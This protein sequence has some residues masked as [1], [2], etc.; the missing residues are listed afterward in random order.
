MLFEDILSRHPAQPQEFRRSSHHLSKRTCSGTGSLVPTQGRRWEALSRFFAPQQ[1]AHH[2]LRANAVH[3]D[4]ASVSRAK[5]TLI[6]RKPRYQGMT[7]EA[8]LP[9]C[10]RI[11]LIILSEFD[12]FGRDVAL[13]VNERK[14]PGSCGVK[15][16][17]S[18]LSNG[19]YFCRPQAG[20]FVQTN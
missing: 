14:A 10:L 20:N 18:N 9:D 4:P 3:S 8:G 15:F 6:P 5:A 17:G 1:G 2:G 16:V 7:L 13:L 11:Q 19:V 12:L